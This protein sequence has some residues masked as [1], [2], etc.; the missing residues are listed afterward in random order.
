MVLFFIFLLVIGL[1]VPLI[2][3]YAILVGTVLGLPLA[4]ALMPFVGYDREN[5]NGDL[6]RKIG[7]VLSL[8]FVICV[9]VLLVVV[10]YLAPLYTCPHCHYFNCIPLTPT[11]CLSSELRIIHYDDY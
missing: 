2:D 8:T 5:K 4:F 9:F 6:F 11:Y 1:F 7:L 10:F 3:N